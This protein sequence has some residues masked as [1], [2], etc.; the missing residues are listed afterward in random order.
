MNKKT[1]QFI[2]YLISGGVYFWV[3]Y[4]GFAFFDKVLHWH[5]FWAVIVS[6]LIGW[7]ANY[8]MQR[9]WVFKSHDLKNH[10]TQITGRYIVITLADFLLNYLILRQLKAVGVSPYIGQFISAAFFTFWNYFWYRFWVF[11]EKF[12]AGHRSKITIM[13]LLAHHSHGH[14]TY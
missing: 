6:N 5:L 10:P 3:G 12:P 11:P 7:T 1:K 13:R 4:G 8:L 2:E 14:N 9:Y